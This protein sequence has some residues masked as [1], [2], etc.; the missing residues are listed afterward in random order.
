MINAFVWI[1][2]KHF[3]TTPKLNVNIKLEAQLKIQSRHWAFPGLAGNT[4]PDCVPLEVLSLH[5]SSR[6][7]L[8]TF[9]HSALNWHRHL[10]V[11]LSTFS[12][13][14]QVNAVLKARA[15]RE[16][17]KGHLRPS[18][19]L[20]L[21]NEMTIDTLP[22]SGSFYHQLQVLILLAECT[23]N[24]RRGWRL[25]WATYKSNHS[26]LPPSSIPL[27]PFWDLLSPPAS[28]LGSSLI[29]THTYTHTL[30]HKGGKSSLKPPCSLC[31][32]LYFIR[33]G[34]LCYHFLSPVI[35][36]FFFFL[37]LSVSSLLAEWQ[38]GFSSWVP[39]VP[40]SSGSA[41]FGPAEESGD[42]SHG[43]VAGQSFDAQVTVICEENHLPLEPHCPISLMRHEVFCLVF[44]VVEAA[45]QNHIIIVTLLSRSVFTAEGNRLEL[46]SSAGQG[47][48]AWLSG[49]EPFL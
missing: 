47:S 11:L 30:R 26:T 46:I 22:L 20:S 37:C 25:D 24:S 38:A 1:S 12:L 14:S 35:S 10:A 32:C 33:S 8:T 48:E 18:L 42:V 28:F 44:A 9:S 21:I 2:R 43:D 13:S 6:L 31:I 16:V 17:W 19:P 5:E 41:H 29:L 23:L 3:L 39:L 7:T 36:L 40:A 45:G 49:F 15:V 27:L 4:I 34:L